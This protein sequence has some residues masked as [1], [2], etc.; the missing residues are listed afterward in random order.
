VGDVTVAGVAAARTGVAVMIQ[1]VCVG[2]TGV[3]VT[4]TTT[5]VVHAARLDR[6]S[7]EVSHRSIEAREKD[8]PAFI[9]HLPLATQDRV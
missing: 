1:G 8:L 9:S 3:A 4:T 6:T 2:G 7:S 5:V